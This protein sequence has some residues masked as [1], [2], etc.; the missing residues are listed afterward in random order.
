MNPAPDER[1]EPVRVNGS[2]G[3]TRGAQTVL[4]LLITFLVLAVAKPWG[5]LE[6]GVDTLPQ[7]GTT[8]PSSDIAVA[9][10][11]PTSAWP[12]DPNATSCLGPSGLVVVTLVRWP[13]HE[14][15]TWQP[16]TAALSEEQ[17]AVATDPIVVRS[18]HIVGL[19]ICRIETRSGAALT[20]AA[21][22][23]DVVQL[24]AG[25]PPGARRELGAP[26]RISVDQPNPYLGIL[27]GPPAPVETP[28]PL[29]LPTFESGNP[30]SPA[31][32]TPPGSSD[33]S[34]SWAPGSYAVGIQFPSRGP[35]T[36]LWVAVTVVPATGE[37]D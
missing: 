26:S 1:P 13:G 24:G 8:T 19:G 25:A 37:P 31:G 17:A 2:G 7:L 23:V 32:V 18:S 28:D 4:A 10:P 20:A 15:R 21:Q 33:S 11:S 9:S 12:W 30:P 16:A 22:I 14:V 35:E 34:P 5:S 36:L 3:R 27:Y 6:V 29:P